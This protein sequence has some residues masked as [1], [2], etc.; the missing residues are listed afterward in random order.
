MQ[1]ENI[2]YSS[3]YLSPSQKTLRPSWC[4][5]L[6]TG[7]MA[8]G[9]GCKFGAPVFEADVFWK[10]MFCVETS[11][12]DIVGTFRRPIVILRLNLGN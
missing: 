10:Q 9:S 5:K 7:L 11:A 3:K 8:H 12:G 6:V 2:G 4:P 1:F